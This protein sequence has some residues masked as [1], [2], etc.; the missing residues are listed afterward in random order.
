MDVGVLRAES[1]GERFLCSRGHAG[2]QERPSH[3]TL[4]ETH[5]YSKISSQEVSGRAVT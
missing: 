5:T 3:L 2:P 1:E 4:E